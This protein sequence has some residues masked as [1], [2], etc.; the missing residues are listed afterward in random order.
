M[1]EGATELEGFEGV[2]TEG[3]ELVNEGSTAESKRGV[4]ERGESAW[5]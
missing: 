5:A 1:R 4:G 3:P 2:E